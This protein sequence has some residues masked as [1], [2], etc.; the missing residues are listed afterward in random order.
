MPLARRSWVNETVGASCADVVMAWRNA[1]KLGVGVLL[2]D[3]RTVDGL[4]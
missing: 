2:R 3:A 1:V 4:S